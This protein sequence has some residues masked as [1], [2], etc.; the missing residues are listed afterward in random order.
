MK[1]NKKFNNMGDCHSSWLEVINRLSIL[2][3]NLH[4]SLGVEYIV[5]LLSLVRKDMKCQMFS[6]IQ[7]IN[8]G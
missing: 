6:N 2:I 7:N 3:Y 1:N 8:N 5:V 4:A